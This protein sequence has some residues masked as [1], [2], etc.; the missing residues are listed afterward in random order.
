MTSQTANEIEVIQNDMLQVGDNPTQ[1]HMDE[2]NDALN[3]IWTETPQHETAL[4]MIQA[5][6]Q[7]LA[8]TARHVIS[9]SQALMR[10]ANEYRD[11]VKLLTDTIDDIKEMRL[12]NPLASEI[13]SAIYETTVEDY[14]E[15]FWDDLLYEMAGT[16]GNG[17]NHWDAHTLYEVIALDL[18]EVDDDDD[19]WYGF[20]RPEL[21]AFRTQLLDMIKKLSKRE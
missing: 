20:T 4:A 17:W 5:N 7:A 19:S 18:D 12:S 6:A 13:Y 3:K 14:N 2:I 15:S 9:I 11:Q 16:L 1:H 21:E 8:N 10:V